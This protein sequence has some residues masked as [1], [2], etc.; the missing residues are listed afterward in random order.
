MRTTLARIAQ[1]ESANLK[2]A[3]NSERWGAMCL[4][5]LG[6]PRAHPVWFR[7]MVA[8][9]HLGEEIVLPD[10]RRFLLH[11]VGWRQL[12]HWLRMRGDDNS[13]RI[14]YRE[15]ELELMSPSPEHED[16]LGDIERLI[17]VFC[18]ETG[19][20]LTCTR[21]R[22]LKEQPLLRAA[23]PDTSYVLGGRRPGLPD[24]V[25]E[26]VWTRPLL[27]KL[28]VYFDLGVR[29]VWAWSRSRGF[30]VFRRGRSGYVR[31]KRSALVPELDLKLLARFI[32]A[33]NQTRAARTYRAALRAERGRRRH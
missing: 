14:T 30:E 6:T 18:D 22:T 11:G 19:V 13:A 5:A 23:E 3:H 25:I 20:E 24:I 28:A 9:I 16:D 7:A 15:G 31:A 32:G 33:P 27:D 10:E 2:R 17:P 21:S 4:D 26:V 8:P 29:E 1:M 12:E